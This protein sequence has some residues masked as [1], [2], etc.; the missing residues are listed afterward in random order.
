MN[1]YSFVVIFLILG[2]IIHA[3]LLHSEIK[4]LRKS[5]HKVIK[6]NMRLFLELNEL[7]NKIIRTTKSEPHQ[8]LDDV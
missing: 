1:M 2:W 7:E 6:S 8:E 5:R 3:T 4:S